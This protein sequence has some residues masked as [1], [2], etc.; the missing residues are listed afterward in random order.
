LALVEVRAGWIMA[1]SVQQDDVA[2]ACSFK[3]GQH[4]I[5][6]NARL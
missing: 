6:A 1:T 3:G 4:F 2:R 5:E